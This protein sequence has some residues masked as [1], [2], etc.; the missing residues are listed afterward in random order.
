MG[1]KDREKWKIR[2]KEKAWEK[3]PEM[4][5]VGEKKPARVPAPYP[6]PA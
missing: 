2:V 1:A 3:E 6:V 4:I 5:K